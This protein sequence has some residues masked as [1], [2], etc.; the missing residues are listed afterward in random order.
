MAN[1]YRWAE[2]RDHRATAIGSRGASP[3]LR[4]YV[5]PEP[6]DPVA[7]PPGRLKLA[8]E[9][10][11]PPGPGRRRRRS[12]WLRVARFFAASCP[13]APRSRPATP[14][15]ARADRRRGR[16]DAWGFAQRAYRSLDRSSPADDETPLRPILGSW[17]TAVSRPPRSGLRSP[18]TG[19]PGVAPRPKRRNHPG[20][21]ADREGA[22]GV[23]VSFNDLAGATEH[24]AGP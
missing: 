21:A 16:A 17:R 22:R 6:L 20:C 2:G 5:D 1:R 24:G 18:M 7:S 3:G 14:P 4:I 9:A 19:G 11:L 23:V 8:H 13:R 10:Q 15:E 12:G